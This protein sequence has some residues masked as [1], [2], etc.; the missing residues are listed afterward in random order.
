MIE[1]AALAGFYAAHGVW[2][3]SEGETLIPLIGYEQPDGSRGMDRYMS[4]DVGQS[5][6]AAQAAL[7]SNDHRATRA[8]L[9]ADAYL[10]MEWGRTD[11]LVVRAVDHGPT[12]GSMELAI[13]YSPPTATTPF[14]VYRLQIIE[15]TGFADQDY[16]TLADAFFDGVDSH[17][18]A[19][20]VW[21]AH[22]DQS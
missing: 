5:A 22:L 20:T 9:V 17:P 16:D 1:T 4:D 14:T 21:S 15:V 12:P 19:A 3:V 6:Q 13:P 7:D 2:S 8:V 10:T 18:D 11:A